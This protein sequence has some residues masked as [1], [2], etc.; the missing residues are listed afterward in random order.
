MSK[1]KR[2]RILTKRYEAGYEAIEWDVAHGQFFWYA[3]EPGITAC[4][5]CDLEF[6]E[7][8]FIECGRKLDET[9]LPK[10]P[11]AAVPE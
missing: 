10:A 7:E 5:P 8:K 4:F 1:T 3:E 9:K 2:L 6:V 11:A